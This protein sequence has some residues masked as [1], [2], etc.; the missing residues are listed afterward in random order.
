M[1][2]SLF[3]ICDKQQKN[4]YSGA[5]TCAELEE[6]T[7]C[8]KLLA[9]CTCRNDKTP[10]SSNSGEESTIIADASGYQNLCNDDCHTIH[11]HTIL[12]E[13]RD[14]SGSKGIILFVLI[15]ILFHSRCKVRIDKKTDP[16]LNPDLGIC[17]Q[18]GKHDRCMRL[19]EG[20]HGLRQSVL[21]ISRVCVGSSPSRSEKKTV[22]S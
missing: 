16:G 4:S 10:P 22:I 2:S 8:A 6:K 5:L 12:K 1:N 18:S 13:F 20:R 15:K 7:K 14:H 11:F 19:G 17:T 3:L 21:C 9:R